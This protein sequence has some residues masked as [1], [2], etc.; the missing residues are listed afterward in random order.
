[1]EHFNGIYIVYILR[2]RKQETRGVSSE[3][4]KQDVVTLS[5]G[6]GKTLV[7]LGTNPSLLG[8]AVVSMFPRSLCLSF[9]RDELRELKEKLK[10]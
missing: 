7:I 8:W 6:D 9:I 3:V 1:M 10:C 2:N 4:W 5:A